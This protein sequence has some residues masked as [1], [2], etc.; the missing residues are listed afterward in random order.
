[1]LDASG[2]GWVKHALYGTSKIIQARGPDKHLSE[3]GR[4]FFLTVRVIEISRALIYNDSTYLSEPIWKDLM[5]KMWANS[6]HDWH[7][8]EF[9]F[10]LMVD[11]IVLSCR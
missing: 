1:M 4:T 5:G 10:D 3:P 9:L 8:K 7:L 11:C 6:K 2:E